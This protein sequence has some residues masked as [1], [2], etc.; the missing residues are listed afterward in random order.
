[1][2]KVIVD[3]VIFQELSLGSQGGMVV[4]V[5]KNFNAIGYNLKENGLFDAKMD[6][7]VRYFQRS[8]D[9]LLV[10]GVVGVKTMMEI[11]TVFVEQEKH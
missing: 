11:D 7:M 6:E 8:R 1:M 10:D 3:E 4:I 5:Q 2:G 9:N